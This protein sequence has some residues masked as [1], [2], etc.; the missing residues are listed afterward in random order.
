MFR[1]LR[2][3]SL[4]PIFLYITCHSDDEVDWKDEEL[5]QAGVETGVA[6]PEPEDKLASL[7]KSWKVKEQLAQKSAAKEANRMPSLCVICL[8]SFHA[9]LLSHPLDSPSS[10]SLVAPEPPVAPLHTLEVPPCVPNGYFAA[11]L[12][13]ACPYLTHT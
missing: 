8:W 2:T 4:L 6:E 9:G 12:S 10:P 3:L 11:S 7:E 13:I 1:A 5:L